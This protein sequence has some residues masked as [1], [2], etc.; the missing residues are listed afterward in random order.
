LRKFDNIGGERLD[1]IQIPVDSVINILIG[2]FK[3]IGISVLILVAF[4]AVENLFSDVK[5]SV[6]AGI[7]KY[8]DGILDILK[9]FGYLSFAGLAFFITI[10]NGKV[11][12]SYPETLSLSQCFVIFLSLFEGFSNLISGIKGFYKSD[13]IKFEKNIY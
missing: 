9:C 5:S 1:N 11:G 13:D 3:I 10:K 4:F 2:L 8:L 7:L 6:I 12:F